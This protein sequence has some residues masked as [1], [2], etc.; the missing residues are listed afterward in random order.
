[1]KA[2]IF[3]NDFNRII[4]ATKEFVSKNENN[5][6]KLYKFIR[7]EFHSADSSVTAVAVDGYRLSVE[8]AVCECDEDFVSYINADTK[9]PGGVEASI[10]VANGET[11]IRCGDYIYG[12]CMRDGEFLDWENALP[13][14]DPTFCFG[15]NGEYLLSALKAAK[16]SCGKSFNQPVILEFRGELSP[17]ILRTNKDDIKMVLPVRIKGQ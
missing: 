1:M 9:L 15:V 8:H 17:V 13:K 7:L 3:T 10:E 4:A 2:K 16:I 5:F 12:C 14:G 6:R 11:I